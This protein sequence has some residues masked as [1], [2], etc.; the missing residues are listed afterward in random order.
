MFTTILHPFHHA[1]IKA[2]L[3]VQTVQTSVDSVYT[4]KYLI[5]NTLQTTVQSVDKIAFFLCI[6]RTQQ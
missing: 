2:R 5:S 1:C 3:K 6:A 4:P